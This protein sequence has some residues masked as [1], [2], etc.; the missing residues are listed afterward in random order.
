[1]K[2]WFRKY[3]EEDDGATIVEYAV[4]IALVAMAC[5]S[6]L[7]QMGT[8]LNETYKTLASAVGGMGGIGNNFGNM[9]R[10]PMMS[11]QGGGRAPLPPLTPGNCGTNCMTNDPGFGTMP[12]KPPGVNY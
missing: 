6:T 4:L 12:V 7:N 11:P 3:Q 9:P 10:S 2:Q 1:M 5:I 8:S